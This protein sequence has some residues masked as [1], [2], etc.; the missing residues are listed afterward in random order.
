MA[1]SSPTLGWPRLCGAIY[2][3]SR[4]WGSCS[5]NWLVGIETL[6]SRLREAVVAARS[7]IE[8]PG[9]VCAWVTI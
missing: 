9:Q 4:K 6:E 3:N 5:V 7:Q 8:G 2:R 1:F